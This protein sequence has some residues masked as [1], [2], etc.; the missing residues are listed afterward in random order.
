MARKQNRLGVRSDQVDI[1]GRPI[2]PVFFQNLVN[3][4]PAWTDLLSYVGGT[5][6]LLPVN[7]DEP[8]TSPIF[9]NIKY[10]D[11]LRIGQYF[12]YRKSP[13]TK[14]GLAKIRGIRG[15][16]LIWNQ[17]IQNGNFDSISA[18]INSGSSYTVSNG[19]ATVKSTNA[20][21]QFGIYQRFQKKANHKYFI[22]FEMHSFG[23]IR[24]RRNKFSSGQET[25][26]EG[27][28]QR[29][30]TASADATLGS[31]YQIC[32]GEPV[33]DIDADYFTLKN[34][35]IIDLTL[36]GLDSITT[37]DE[38]TALFPLPYYAY[39]TGSLLSF[40]GTGLK[41]T[42]KNLINKSESESGGID[43]SGNLINNDQHLWRGT[44]FIPV[45]EGETYT[46]SGFGEYYFVRIYY[47]DSGFNFVSPRQQSGQNL[48]ITFTVP[49]GVKYVKWTLYQS[50]SFIT[51]STFDASKIQLSIGS[52]IDSYEPYT[53]STLSLP[54][55]T[56][57]PT[58][59]KSAGSVYDELTPTRAITRIGAVDLGS[60]TWQKNAT[61]QFFASYSGEQKVQ[62]TNL[63]SVLPYTPSA[64]GAYD[65]N[66]DM[67]I[68]IRANAIWIRDSSYETSS[69]FA[70][71][72]SGVYLFY[73]L[74]T[75]VVEATMSFE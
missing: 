62:T 68:T 60:L 28:Y 35:M 57:F 72:L 73:E 47:Y 50:S 32:F 69:A 4:L 1:Y 44:V 43:A 40:N 6:Q 29:I 71:A 46:F 45:S 56:F 51:Q 8:D 65:G 5:E 61:G 20:S 10:P 54:I 49:S 17:L 41:V 55:S 25:V 42:G 2:S 33:S 7:D 75:P 24:V 36:M 30:E 58:G 53:S 11:L 34:Y 22:S 66:I 19:I 67:T 48:P 70:S 14:D 38:F 12:T 18:W 63:K 16:T 27:I 15:N 39:D 21:N 59:M 52:S 31:A 74:A 64:D 3:D 37:V 23:T 13:T 26:T 9:C